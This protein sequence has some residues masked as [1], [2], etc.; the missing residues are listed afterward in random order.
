MADLLGVNWD[1]LGKELGNDLGSVLGRVTG[2]GAKDPFGGRNFGASGDSFGGQRFGSFSDPFGG[3][4]FGTPSL[5][6]GGQGFGGGGDP[7]GGQSFATTKDPFGGMN[8]GQFGKKKEESIS[9]TVTETPGST[10]SAANAMGMGSSAYANMLNEE[11]AKYKDAP[12]LAEVAQAVM[13][14]ES[15]GRPDAQGVVVTKGPYAGQRAQGLM[16]IMPGNYPGVNLLD[17]RTNVQ[18]GLEM[19]YER[20]KKYGNW[21]SAVA[22]YFGA[23]DSQG[24]PTTEADDNETT[25]IEYVTIVSQHRTK[26]RNT[27]AAASGGGTTPPQMS[28]IWGNAPG[29]MMQG[30]AVVS[31]GVDQRIYAYGR[32]YGLAAG[33]TGIDIGLKRG[34]QL[35]MPTGLTGVVE[36]AGGSGVFRD[37]DGGDPGNVPGRGEL[38]IRLS[39]GDV[40]ILGHNSAINVKVGQ[41]VSG[42]QL[43]GLSG[44]AAGEHLHLEVRQ[45][46]AQGGYTLVNPLNYF[47]RPPAAGGG[48]LTP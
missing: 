14:L 33:H 22:S 18:K 20:Y 10:S 26:I 35:Y 48:N 13:E 23:V 31:P 15:Q 30:Y 29:S 16:Q 32:E 3:R 45:R 12:E 46:N 28:S 24:R 2:G 40:M 38:R 41:Q 1:R 7:F 5:A 19:L 42:G 6:F 36:I 8:F 44:S 9:R 17:P 21:D 11:A 37:E 27:R 34:T 39:N 47:A 25:G 43:L 4:N